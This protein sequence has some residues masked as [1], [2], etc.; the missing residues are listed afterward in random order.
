MPV[1]NESADKL[2]LS[3]N[4]I[5]SQTYSNFEFVIVDDGSNTETKQILN[6]L[7][8]KRIV[9]YTCKANEGISKALNIG[10]KLC[11]GDFILRQDSDNISN[12]TRLESFLEAI[13][14]DQADLVYSNFT[15]PT[16][17]KSLTQLEFLPFKMIFFNHIE[18]NVM[19]KKDAVA[20][21]G[22]Y[23]EELSRYQDYLLWL[24][25]ITANK[26]ISF[27]NEDLYYYGS[28][29]SCIEQPE[30]VNDAA[31]NYAC[32]ILGYILNKSSF[33]KIRN[34][35]RSKQ[36][37]TSMQ[38]IIYKNMVNTFAKKLPRQLYEKFLTEYY[39]ENS[40]CLYS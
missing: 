4:S 23:P 14:K 20:S 34:A 39:Y 7:T 30:P 38:H 25:L 22:Y 1:F 29:N 6:K 40:S 27:I 21:V 9:L 36:K 12:Q 10:F 17:N 15:T 33:I 35:I 18:H 8:D 5:I 16:Q 24:K 3:L 11:R 31:F 19:L 28:N 2:Q 13:E 32:Y 26:K 37:L